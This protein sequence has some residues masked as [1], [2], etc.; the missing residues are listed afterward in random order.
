M[1]AQLRVETS[2]NEIVETLH[3]MYQEKS[4]VKIWQKPK[5]NKTSRKVF[6]LTIQK[7]NKRKNTFSL[8]ANDQQELMDID[9]NTTVYIRGEERSILFKQTKVELSKGS[10]CLVIPYEVRLYERRYKERIKFSYDEKFMLKMHKAKKPSHQSE[11]KAY[12]LIDVSSC[13]LAIFM[14]LQESDFFSKGDHIEIS[15]IHEY[16]LPISKAG[17]IIYFKKIDTLKNGKKSKF[18]RVGVKFFMEYHEEDFQIIKMQLH[19]L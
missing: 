14:T 15:K 9:K 16:N 11:T 8:I 13:G 2:Y 4:P 5:D 12:Q 7:I 10:L 6:D 3:K 17:K 19:R 1:S 18:I